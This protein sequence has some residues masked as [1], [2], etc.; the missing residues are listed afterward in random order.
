MAVRSGKSKQIKA[1]VFMEKTKRKKEKA[2]SLE[3]KK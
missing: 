3:R 1:F 2:F